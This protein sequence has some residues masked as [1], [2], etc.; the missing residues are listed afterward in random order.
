MIIIIVCSDL[1]RHVKFGLLQVDVE[2]RVYNVN[3]ISPQVPHHLQ[4]L[5]WKVCPDFP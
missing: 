5:E 1:L 3:L 2:G 4:D